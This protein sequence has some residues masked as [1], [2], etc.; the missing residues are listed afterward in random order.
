MH[1]VRHLQTLAFLR[2]PRWIWYSFVVFTK[3]TFKHLLFACHGGILVSLKAT[4]CS[5]PVVLNSV[6]NLLGKHCASSLSQQS[7]TTGSFY[8]QVQMYIDNPQLCDWCSASLMNIIIK[9]LSTLVFKSNAQWKYLLL[10]FYLYQSKLHN[11]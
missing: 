6:C 8:L 1:E 2:V 11:S 10:Q 9:P 5:D 4:E 7:K 3:A